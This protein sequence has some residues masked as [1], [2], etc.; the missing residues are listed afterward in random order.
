MGLA[1]GK[2]FKLRPDRFYVDGSRLSAALGTTISELKKTLRARDS[3]MQRLETG[4]TAGA[5]DLVADLV[6][7]VTVAEGVMLPLDMVSETLSSGDKFRQVTSVRQMALCR[8]FFDNGI[9][10]QTGPPLH[11]CI[12]LPEG[13]NSDRTDPVRVLKV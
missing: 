8:S 2:P 11:A 6:D 12:I 9:Q 3:D 5:T 13:V 10:Q 1:N 7:K 4:A